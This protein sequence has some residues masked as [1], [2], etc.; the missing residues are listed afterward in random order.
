MNT[1]E[2]DSLMTTFA[3]QSSDIALMAGLVTMSVFMALLAIMVTILVFTIIANWK[4][5]TKAGEA[6]WKSLIPIYSSVILY[7]IAGIS[8]WLILLYL[9]VW[10][11]V[12]GPLISLGLT[13]Y[14]M[15][16]LANAFGKS[17]GFAVGLILL[18]TIFIMI[19]A[20]GNSEYQLNLKND[21][22]EP[23]VI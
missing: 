13:I 6:G 2:Y 5:F 20:F 19:L 7:R 4:I 3:D 18:N 15:I 16:N 9:L 23:K 1:T 17:T 12:I 10:V 22:N 21:N 8:P 11:P 14:L